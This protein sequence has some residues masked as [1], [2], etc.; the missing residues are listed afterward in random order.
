MPVELTASHY[1]A[2]LSQPIWDMTAG[3][4]LRRAA[5]LAGERMA[6]VEVVPEGMASLVGMAATDRRW[7]Y[8]ELLAEAEACAA[9]LLTRFR[10][11]DHVCLWAPNVP[12]WVI[13]Q[14]GAALAG[15]VLV[16]A[17]P[18][19]RAEELRHVLDRA[20]AKA[21]I[22]ASAFR[23]TDMAAIAAVVA[24]APQPPSMARFGSLCNSNSRT[25]AA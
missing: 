18:S 7:T 9:W 10:P 25:P 13:V 16:T 24:R 22:H 23:G 8:A 2:D 3:D 21:L 5:A 12:E 15:L 11:G 1:S 19:L 4:A 20:Q 14:Y 6:L 17:N